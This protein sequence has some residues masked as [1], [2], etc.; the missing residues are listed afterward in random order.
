M[1]IYLST[2]SFYG[3]R[4]LEENRLPKFRDKH[5]DQT[6]ESFGF[7]AEEMKGYGCQTG[8]RILPY[9][10]QDLYS[11]EKHEITCKAIVLENGHIRAVFLPQYGMRLISLYSF[12][13]KRELLFKNPA[14]QFANL[15]I[16]DA[17]FA[18]GIE[19]NIGQLGH[20][21]TTSD[22]V[23]AGVV[24]GENGEEILR[25][26]EYE[27]C[28]GLYWSVDFSLEEG[29]R[30]LTAYVRVI[31]PK[32][33][34][35]PM[36]WW[37][38]IAVPEEDGTRIFSGTKEVIYINPSSNESGSSVK[39][40]SHG[41]M[42]YLPSLPERDASYPVNF[43]FSS[44]YFFQ[45]EE[46]GAKTWEAA[47]YPDDFLFFERSTPFLRYRK[48]FCWGTQQGGQNWKNYLSLKGRGNYVELQAGLAPTQM[49]GIMMPGET[50]W[51]F[52]QV[53]GGTGISYHEMSGS[54]QEGQ[55]V[56]QKAVNRAVSS[57]SL[58]EKLRKG[59][60]HAD[61]P[62]LRLLHQGS[63][64][65]ALE[66]IRSPGCTSR[67]LCFPESS[68][69]EREELWLSLLRNSFIAD[70][71]VDE[72][73]PS[74]MVDERYR[75][76]L[77][78]AASGGG[79]LA[80]VLL[81]ILDYENG[82]YEKGIALFE[83]SNAIRK[84]PLALRNLFAAWKDRDAKKA[85]RYMEEALNLFAVPRREYMEEYVEFLMEQKLYEK[86]W[87]FYE[88]LPEPEKDNEFVRMQL[89]P[90]AVRLKKMDFLEK[91][92]QHEFA[93]IREGARGYT[94]NYFVYQALLESEEQGTEFDEE[95]VLKYMRQNEVPMEIDFRQNSYS[96]LIP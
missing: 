5:Y 89:L 94:D 52:V 1:A 4:K 77:E 7:S 44:E 15:A 64:F 9:L 33:E 48:M 78:K 20:A 31:N 91:Q 56:A 95:L 58:E 72:L 11:R 43:N 41:Q 25:C 60:E 23:F 38:N 83:K 24:K 14:L 49:H 50:V 75:M 81:G 53:F 21:F 22:S 35:V 40:M 55:K 65:G 67:G 59:R 28:K 80:N 32:K 6:L 13:Q 47:A 93:R 39:G 2:V 85:A 63:G 29:E 68:V 79:Y 66:E 37:T 76:F 96:S 54:W 34:A 86:A 26:Y 42:P 19:W 69:T 61:L 16:R 3:N 17:W 87:A 90:A 10:V 12:D 36:Y 71:P 27:R 74:Y 57:K 45:N 73:P 8:K 88:A 30:F 51:D 92:Y 62:V 18:G 82:Q 70:I 46:D 84:N